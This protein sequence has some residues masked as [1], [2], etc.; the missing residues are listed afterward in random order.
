VPAPAASQTSPVIIKRYTKLCDD[1]YKA[2]VLGE[3]EISYIASVAV[4][5]KIR[6][7][8]GGSGR[9]AN[10]A[11]LGTMTGFDISDIVHLAKGDA[12]ICRTSHDK[13][14]VDWAIGYSP[15]SHLIEELRVQLVPPPAPPPFAAPPVAGP[16]PSATPAP[17]PPVI[18]MTAPTTAPAAAPSAKPVA[19]TQTQ[20]CQMFPTLC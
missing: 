12:F 6:K 4:A 7:D 11:A 3:H 16:P 18:A 14:Q 19:P 13:G 8:T 17:A 9:Y 20:A 15:T 5:A 10:V 2:S 1:I